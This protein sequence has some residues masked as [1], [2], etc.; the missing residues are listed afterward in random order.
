MI[1]ATVEPLKLEH[2]QHLV[3]EGFT[4]EQIAEWQQQGLRSLTQQEAWD[5]GFKVKTKEGY[6]SGSGL[7]IPFTEDFGQLRLD[8]PLERHKGQAAKYLTLIGA[9]SEAGLPDNC[10]VI[11]EGGKDAHAGTVH[12]GIPRERS[13]ELVITVKPC[14][15]VLVT[16]FYLTTMAGRILLSFLIYSTR[17]SGSMAKFSYYPRFQENRKRGYASTL[18]LVIPP[19]TTSS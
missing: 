1:L 13:P 12:G 11:T 9:K 3:N 2:Q 14:P 19:P 17:V 7:Y 8:M 4:P 16:P 5:M 18:K 15:K 6:Q 10:K